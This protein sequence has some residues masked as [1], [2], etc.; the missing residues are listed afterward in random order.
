MQNDTQS[1]EELRY[2]TGKFQRPISYHKEDVRDQINILSALPQWLDH[3]IENLDEAQLQTPYRP[4]D[5][6]CIR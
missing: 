5:G 2:P 1:I 4:V 3:A 6:Q